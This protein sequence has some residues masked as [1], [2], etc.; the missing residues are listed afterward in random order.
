MQCAKFI[1]LEKRDVEITIIY[2]R[3]IKKAKRWAND[4][5]ILRAK[6]K[7][8]AVWHVINK[9]AGKSLKYDKKIE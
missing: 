3:V 6:N 2:K 4:K 1:E 9:E 8:K 5:Y 7:T